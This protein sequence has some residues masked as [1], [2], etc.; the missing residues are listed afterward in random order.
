MTTCAPSARDFVERERTG[1][2]HAQ[3]DAIQQC[4]V[5][6]YHGTETLPPE[7]GI[8]LGDVMHNARSALD[9]LVWQLVLANGQ[10]PG[11]H[12]A[13]PICTTEGG[14]NQ[15]VAN[16]APNR[17]PSPLA[18]V[19]EKCWTFI[20]DQQ[21]WTNTEVADVGRL[22]LANLRRFSNIDKHRMVHSTVAY[23]AGQTPTIEL[24]SPIAWIGWE[25]FTP[26][27]TLLEDGA[28][29]ARVQVRLPPDV[30][31]P[32]MDVHL[33]L[34]TSI[35][36]GQPGSEYVPIVVFGKILDDVSTIV[37]ELMVRAA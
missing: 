15:A 20:R 9:H 26:P 11:K 13:F 4:H 1:R 21:P 5:F 19:S 16:R 32:H 29:V 14:W 33:N 34:P 25:Q 10:R 12:S 18:G 2:F 37:T 30:E 17:G 31:N 36:F 28:E 8:I 22:P 23:L 7:W 24:G 6:I 35:M 3:F 27:G